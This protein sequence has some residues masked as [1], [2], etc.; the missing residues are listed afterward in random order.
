MR[1]HV[2]LDERTR[3]LKAALGCTS[4]LVVGVLQNLVTST[5]ASGQGGL[6]ARLGDDD[7]DV[8]LRAYWNEERDADGKPRTGEL[9]KALLRARLIERDSD[10]YYW[11]VA[12][13]DSYLI[14]LAK[15]RHVTDV[16]DY[17]EIGP[18]DETGSCW[19]S[20]SVEHQHRY[21]TPAGGIARIQRAGKKW[22]VLVN[23]RPLRGKTNKPVTREDPLEAAA[24][25]AVCYLNT[26]PSNRPAP[27]AIDLD[28][29]G[30]RP[31]A[32]TEELVTWGLAQA[33]IS[34]HLGS[35]EISR[36]DLGSAGLQEQE[37]RQEHEQRVLH[38][39]Q[40]LA[41]TGHPT[42]AQHLDTAA[43]RWVVEHPVWQEWLAISGSPR[44]P[45]GVHLGILRQAIVEDNPEVAG[46]VV[47]GVYV[48]QLILGQPITDFRYFAEI[49]G[50][51]VER[52]RWPLTPNDSLDAS[53]EYRRH[54]E[55]WAQVLF[56]G[57]DQRRILLALQRCES[58]IAL[59][60]VRQGIVGASKRAWAK[61]P[62]QTREALL[63][64][65]PPGQ[66][67]QRR[68]A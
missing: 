4:S 38:A 57:D 41:A 33:T 67:D 52:V 62:T 28:T 3:R 26:E 19:V 10:G 64:G 13:W 40:D 45:T 68:R 66:H 43:H 7:F 58:T 17:L 48:R 24:H 29:A 23:G 46:E 49:F 50:E 37:H 53:G 35:S 18:E 44:G 2:L 61:R 56:D 30:P 32:E 22:A 14:D 47:R 31:A 20:L 54:L 55:M 63:S 39:S 60:T 16:A 12:W 6:G 42:G 51:W 21:G 8:E 15:D 65:E 5:Y 36:D 9:A 34:D 27:V 59:E 25:G 11:L 1:E